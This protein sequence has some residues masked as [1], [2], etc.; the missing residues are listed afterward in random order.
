MILRRL[1]ARRQH[2]REGRGQSLAQGQEETPGQELVGAPCAGV[3]VTLLQPPGQAGQRS[4]FLTFHSL[5]PL[6]KL[7]QS[8]S[9][10]PQEAT[11]K[12]QLCL[13]PKHS[14]WPA[15]GQ[16]VA[17]ARREKVP[18]SG[19]ARILSWSQQWRGNKT[20][21]FVSQS[22]GANKAQPLSLAL[23]P[24]W[25]QQLCPPRAWAEGPEE[26]SHSWNLHREGEERS[27]E[28]RSRERPVQPCCAFSCSK[29]RAE[30]KAMSQAGFVLHPSTSVSPSQ[31]AP[32]AKEH[33]RCQ[34]REPGCL[35]QGLPAGTPS[36]EE[37]K[38]P[39]SRQRTPCRWK[40]PS[41]HHGTSGRRCFAEGG[42]VLV[43]VLVPQ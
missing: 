32:W 12:C 13:C 18:V 42:S 19:T 39:G 9:C 15:H 5:I 10:Q 29:G 21:G 38:S 22:E 14:P 4:A 31:A 28:S 7:P 33:Q 3:P 34:G 35:L 40:I 2:R 11:Q 27:W 36:P 41:S 6:P 8:C 20:K 25:A 26:Q 24:S 30:S 43:L 23:E 16:K 1:S 17:R 37:L